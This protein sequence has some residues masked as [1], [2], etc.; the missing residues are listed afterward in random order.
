[1]VRWPAQPN[2]WSRIKM[3]QTGKGVGRCETGAGLERTKFGMSH[4]SRSRLVQQD[5]RT[6]RS[7]NKSI[8]K[9][10]TFGHDELAIFVPKTAFD[11]IRFHFSMIFPL[12]AFPSKVHFLLFV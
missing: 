4:E 1:M 5:E 11:L 6:I 2:S 8:I 7:R 10:T 9:K 12:R 3:T